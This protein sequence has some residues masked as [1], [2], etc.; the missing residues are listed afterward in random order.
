[1][2]AKSSYKRSQLRSVTG[3]DKFEVQVNYKKT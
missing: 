2:I 1:M 3:E